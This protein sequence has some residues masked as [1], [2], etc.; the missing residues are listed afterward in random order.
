LGEDSIVELAGGAPFGRADGRLALHRRP[1][2]VRAGRWEW[3]VV[4]PAVPSSCVVPGMSL[5]RSLLLQ[6][7]R[8]DRSSHVYCTRES[9]GTQVLEGWLFPILMLTRGWRFI[10]GI[11]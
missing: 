7:H 2:A 4:S 9:G 5:A 11:Q 1:G 8:C 10:P 6:S 3:Q